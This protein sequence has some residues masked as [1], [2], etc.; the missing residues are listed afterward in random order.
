MRGEKF[1]RS[2]SSATRSGSP[3]RMRGK[4]SIPPNFTAPCGITPAYAGKSNLGAGKTP[5]RRDHPCVCGEKPG[6][7]CP[8]GLP[9][10]SPPRMRGKGLS[11]IRRTLTTG[12]TPAYAGKSK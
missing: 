8:M 12:I 1:Q 5:A 9:W 4:D 11:L 7:G 6:N 3:P 10:G 2:R